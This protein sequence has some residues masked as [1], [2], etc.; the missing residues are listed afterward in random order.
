MPGT[1]LIESATAANG[2]PTLRA[3]RG[4]GR[5]VHLHSSRNPSADAARWAQ[6]QPLDAEAFV[7]FGLGCGYNLAALLVRLPASTP[8]LVVEP[9]DVLL[10]LAQGSRAAREALA[11]GRV[12]LGHDWEAV[13]RWVRACRVSWDRVGLLTSGSYA[14]AFPAEFGRLDTLWRALHQAPKALA[15]RPELLATK[16]GMSIVVTT[17]DRPDRAASLVAALQRQRG[18]RSG[19]EILLVTDNGDARVFDLVRA[20]P[21]VDG[22]DVRCFNTHYEGY[23]LALANNVG[24]R[25][26]RY[27]TVVCLDDDVQVPDDL[28]AAYQAAPQGLRLGRIDFAVDV[29]GQRRVLADPRG[30]LMQ[31]APRPIDDLVR[32]RGFL[33]GGNFAIPTDIA[34][35]LGG[36]DEAFLDFGEQDLDFGARVMAAARSAVAVPT[37]RVVHDGPSRSLAGQ[38]GVEAPASRPGRALEMMARPDRG[39]VV[40]GGLTYWIGDRW[41]CFVQPDGTAGRS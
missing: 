4:D 9:Y 16:P 20:L 15:R 25:F 31:G 3:A 13:T 8:V 11:S 10:G 27:D 38:F 17:F 19:L 29:E 18:V 26:A 5:R 1:L 21:A 37:A 39:S 33:Y 14:H 6:A 40:N 41:E 32:Y 35:A 7:L 24:I 23:G 12:H 30:S 2:E 36:F 34:R 28:V 22:V